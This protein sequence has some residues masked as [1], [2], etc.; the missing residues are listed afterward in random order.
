MGGPLP[1]KPSPTPPLKVPPACLL[2]GVLEKAASCFVP[3]RPA[4]VSLSLTVHPPFW[5]AEQMGRREAPSGAPRPPG[6]FV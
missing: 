5:T 6:A 1:H 2:W 3:C 4:A